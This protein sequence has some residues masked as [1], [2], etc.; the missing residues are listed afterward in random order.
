MSESV[1]FERGQLILAPFK[2]RDILWAVTGVAKSGKAKLTAHL[3]SY[4]MDITTTVSALPEDWS[5]VS[6][7]EAVYA[8]TGET[9]GEV[10]PQEPEA[11]AGADYTPH[12]Q[13]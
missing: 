5:V 4:V 1:K 9:D 3:G 12:H 10:A 2:G 11:E 6:N 8:L 7:G 13:L